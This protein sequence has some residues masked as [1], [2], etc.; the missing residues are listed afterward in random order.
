MEAGIKSGRLDADALKIAAETIESATTQNGERLVDLAA[1]STVLLIFLRHSG[2]TFC[3]EALAD[4]AASRARAEKAGIRIVLV[5][6]GDWTGISHLLKRYYLTDIGC[7]SDP[8]QKL[9]RVFGLR[10]G[11][12]GQLLGPKV[13][14]RGIQAGIFEGHGVGRPTADA[15]QLPGIFLLK[16]SNVVG[17]FRHRSAADRPDYLAL[18]APYAAD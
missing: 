7:I 15:A 8:E 17:S 9:S 12:I 10:R 16:Q 14:W 1:N 6:M 13:W 3:R 18:C 2:C 5:H 4:I 11:R